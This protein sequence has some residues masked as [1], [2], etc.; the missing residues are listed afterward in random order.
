M[1]QKAFE[2]LAKVEYPNISSQE[3]SGMFQKKVEP[4]LFISKRIGNIY[5]GSLYACLVSLLYKVPD[6]RNKNT[7][8]FSYGSGLCSTM[9]Q[10][11]V[12][13]NPLTQ[14]QISDIDQMFSNRI[15]ISAEDYSKVMKYKEETY[16]KWRG[17][18]EVD[19]NLLADNTFYLEAIDEKWRRVYKLKHLQGESLVRNNINALERINNI[20]KRIPFT[21]KAEEEKSFHKMSISKR[22]STIERQINSCLDQ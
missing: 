3:V 17:K 2:S 19:F 15:K 14:S 6:I 9:L 13:S 11:H 10:A 22:R 16:G 8:L 18:I 1:I 7:L 20:D 12:V 4:T 5:T 21:P